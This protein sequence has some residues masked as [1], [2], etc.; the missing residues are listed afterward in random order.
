VSFTAPDRSSDVLTLSQIRR[1]GSSRSSST[2]SNSSPPATRLRSR[3][4][5]ME[6]NPSTSNKS[7][8][9]GKQ[10]EFCDE[11]RTKLSRSSSREHEA[12]DDLADLADLESSQKS[13]TISPSP[14][15]LRSNHKDMNGHRPGK[16]R[17]ESSEDSTPRTV[18]MKKAKSKISD[19]KKDEDEDE[20]DGD[21][22]SQEEDEVDELISSA[23]ATPPP[24]Q[25]RR[26]PVKRRLRPR[27]VAAH[28]PSSDGDDEG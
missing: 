2:P 21:G 24:L 1:K 9:K 15:R 16:G 27:R 28:T 18:V 12:D 6:S 26:T 5:S 3:K 17:P 11:L 10:V 13:M 8:G 4:V 23:S 22:E 20:D 25:G 7:K 14:R 19:L